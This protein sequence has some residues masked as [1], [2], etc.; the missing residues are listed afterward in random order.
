MFV[1][2]SFFSIKNL[3]CSNDLGLILSRF[4]GNRFFMLTSGLQ[5]NDKCLNS[6]S[7]YRPH[8]GSFDERETACVCV[9]VF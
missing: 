4:N 8:I 6:V 5:K 9:S 3:F 7:A 1:Y 2:I